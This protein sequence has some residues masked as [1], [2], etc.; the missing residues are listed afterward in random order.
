M[1]ILFRQP[2]ESSAITSLNK[3]EISRCMFKH[4]TLGNDAKLV[5]KKIHY[6]A[7][8][9][10]HIIKDG[11]QRYE[12]DGKE[13]ILQSGNFLLIPPNVPHKTTEVKSSSEKFSFTFSTCPHI[14]IQIR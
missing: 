9:E 6:H 10:L 3:I 4:L 8:Y 7:G 13:Y 1:K 5:T 2:D 14:G 12:I 11:M